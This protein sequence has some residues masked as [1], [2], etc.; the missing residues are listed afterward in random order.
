MFSKVAPTVATACIVG[1][2]V[3]NVIPKPLTADV[4]LKYVDVAA[5]SEN[6]NDP[7]VVIAVPTVAVESVKD[8]LCTL[9]EP[10]PDDGLC[11]EQDCA[12]GRTTRA[13]PGS[14]AAVRDPVRATAA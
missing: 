4:V 1:V 9:P 7:F 2:S 5:C 10:E 8:I 12:T 11:R 14:H 13:L 3:L 6:V